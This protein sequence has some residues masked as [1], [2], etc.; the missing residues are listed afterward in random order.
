META[1]PVLQMVLKVSRT[2]QD[3]KINLLIA[4]QEVNNLQVA[5]KQMR[6]DESTFKKVFQGATYICQTRGIGIPDVR[7]RKVSKRADLNYASEFFYET[8]EE[9]LRVS[10]FYPMIDSFVEGIEARFTQET[11]V[12]ISAIMNILRLTASDEEIEVPSKYSDVECDSLRAEL[13]LLK[14]QPRSSDGPDAVVQPLPYEL[15][16]VRLTLVDEDMDL[17]NQ[18]P[19]R[20]RSLTRFNLIECK[21]DNAQRKNKT[22]Q[23]LTLTP[24]WFNTNDC[25]SLF[26]TVSSH[27][28]LKKVKLE[29][30]EHEDAVEL[31]RAVCE[32]GAE[33]RFFL[34]THRVF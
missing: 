33:T 7:Q 25:R 29:V 9:E 31:Y 23:E 34:S 6:L 15:T 3:P 32:T 30:C 2:L 12:L 19:S 21:W 26:E 22:L 16:I 1:H 24:S 5:L 27:V 11:I 13:R 4:F 18:L 14:A 28:S 8:K 10:V 20:N 17:I